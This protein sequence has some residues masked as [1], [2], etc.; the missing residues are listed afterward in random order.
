MTLYRKTGSPF[1]YYDFYV[2]GR[3][4][5]GSTEC[6]DEAAALQVQEALRKPL[7]SKAKRMRQ[8]RDLPPLAA[9][10]QEATEAGYHVV[11]AT[12]GPDGTIQLQFADPASPAPSEVAPWLN[13]AKPN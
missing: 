13:K 1:W 6:T 8:A 10:I 4:Y 9:A 12:I 11:S 3:R 2:H 7:R 5:I